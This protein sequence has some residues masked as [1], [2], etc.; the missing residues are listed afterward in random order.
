MLNQIRRLAYV[1]LFTALPAG[2]DEDPSPPGEAL[3]EI[4]VPDVTPYRTG[5]FRILHLDSESTNV[6]GGALV[7]AGDLR[8]VYHAPDQALDTTEL[9]SP[10]RVIL[11]DDDDSV[12]LEDVLRTAIEQEELP[13]VSI[14]DMQVMI[15]AEKSGNGFRAIPI[16]PPTSYDGPWGPIY[17]PPKKP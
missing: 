2:C 14:D 8:V 6:P 10:R 11:V 1:L 4:Q 15:P 3:V 7:A 13:D 16:D 12:L 5:N 17:V 9:F